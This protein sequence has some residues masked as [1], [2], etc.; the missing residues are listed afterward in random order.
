MTPE[1]Q[2]AKFHPGEGDKPVG[3]NGES[4]SSS[5]GNVTPFDFDYVK[6]ATDAYGEL[7]VYYDRILKES[8][9]D[10]DLA[11]SRLTEDYDKGVRIKTEDTSTAN[12]ATTQ[13][14]QAN[15]LSRGIYQKSLFDPFA[16]TSASTA[17][18]G[19]AD[20]ANPNNP[21]GQTINQSNTNLNRYKEDA[22]IT[23]NRN[24]VDLPEKQRRYAA[25]LEQQRRTEAASMAETRGNRALTK[26]Q[27]DNMVLA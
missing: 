24:K 7:G 19:L 20:L 5:S 17:G 14:N 12:Q 15:A 11:L 1:E 26:W 6:A 9:G 13:S 4:G 3:Y 2:W 16:K 23:L 8:Q 10:L 25:D 18:M 21:Y 27:S 22:T